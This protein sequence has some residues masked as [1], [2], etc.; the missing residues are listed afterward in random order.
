MPSVIPH[1]DPTIGR[2][3]AMSRHLVEQGSIQ[4]E[5]EFTAGDPDSER[6]LEWYEVGHTRNWLSF[7]SALSCY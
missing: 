3:F 1:S 4:I 7:Y 5:Y 6:L 2:R